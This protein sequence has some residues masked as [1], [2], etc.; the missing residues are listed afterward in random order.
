M[1]HHSSTTIRRIA[2]H[3][4]PARTIR[5][6][7]PANDFG[8]DNFPSDFGMRVLI[9]LVLAADGLLGLD[10]RKPEFAEAT[11]R[12]YLR[13][14]EHLA[15][16]LQQGERP[17][18]ATDRS[19]LLKYQP[20]AIRQND[21]D[22]SIKNALLDIEQILREEIEAKALDTNSPG[23]PRVIPDQ[24]QIICSADRIFVRPPPRP[25]H[26]RLVVDHDHPIEGAE[27]S[28]ALGASRSS[29]PYDP[30]Y[31]LNQ[32]LPVCGRRP[33]QI[34]V[35]YSTAFEAESGFVA[36]LSPVLASRL[37][38]IGYE[39]PFLFNEP[40]QGSTLGE[41]FLP[42]I[43][44]RIMAAPGAIILQSAAYFASDICR[45]EFALLMW[46]A[47]HEGLPVFQIFGGEHSYQNVPLRIPADRE[48]R[49]DEIRLSE[50]SDDRKTC[51]CWL[52]SDLG[53]VSLMA[54]LDR[55]KKGAVTHR[56]LA[57]IDAL[58]DRLRT[59]S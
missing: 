18:P 14:A 32:V 51:P 37:R 30:H 31:W 53:R 17:E 25:R 52:Q 39:P 9:P 36:R 46:R 3:G 12:F 54:L 45:L 2:E 58:I 33:G 50:L 59:P 11:R 43:V 38:E 29:N 44:E 4:G 6:P 13:I 24:G 21:S 42:E 26:L 27:F 22:P 49:F 23:M 7:V 35:S 20:N 28:Q 34:F 19:A 15:E 57:V 10:R 16:G 48:G 47:R 40:A 8:F 41:E 5:L 56:L 1:A 55:N